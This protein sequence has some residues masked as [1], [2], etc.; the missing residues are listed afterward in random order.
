MKRL[1]KEK[2]TRIWSLIIYIMGKSKY[3]LS[4]P[5]LIFHTGERCGGT[6]HGEYCNESNE[7]EI[8]WQSHSTSR[9]MTSTMIHE[10]VHHLQFWPWYSRYMRI[11][12]YVNNPYEIEATERA[13]FLEPEI[14]K[15][16]SDREW[17][18]LIRKDVRLRKIYKLVEN[19][20]TIHV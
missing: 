12:G 16:S 10:Y 11:F 9:E 13:K 15:L 4:P 20:I 2:I 18:K 1:N 19:K 3:K 8:W 17:R 6:I 7:I 5:D 14:S